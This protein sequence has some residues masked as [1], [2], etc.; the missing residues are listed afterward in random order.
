MRHGNTFES[1]EIPVQ[2]GARTDLP[3][4]AEGVKQAALM[5]SY[6]QKEKI[7]PEK[8]YAGNLLRQTQSAK[9]I[10]DRF[11][12]PYFAEAALTEIDYGVWEGLTADEIAFR[13]PREYEGWMNGDW[14]GEIFNERWEDRMAK[15]DRWFN[16]LKKGRERVVLA[17]TSNGLLR[18]L[19]NEKV[20]TG[21]FCW[22][23]LSED[24]HTIQK[25]N[26]D[27]ATK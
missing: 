26:V 20:K 8:I 18:L 4:T 2:I 10:G 15:L 14:P 6:L 5:A 7:C 24:S 16:E 12:L 27:P 23:D 25:W 9:I 11:Q 3:L 17:V 21:H 13:W 22:I 1:K 19:R